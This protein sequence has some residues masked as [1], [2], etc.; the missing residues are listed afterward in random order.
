MDDFCFSYKQGCSLHIPIINFH[1]GIKAESFFLIA[2][3]STR[4]YL[5]SI[6]PVCLINQRVY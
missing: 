3:G 6:F 2:S 4:L 5:Y 1:A